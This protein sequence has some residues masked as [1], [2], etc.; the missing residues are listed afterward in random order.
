MPAGADSFSN[1]LRMGV[2]VFHALKEILKSKKLST[3]VGD[4]GGFAPALASNTA[5]LDLLMEAIETA[6]YRPGDDVALALDIAASEFAEDERPLSP[7]PR[8]RGAS[9]P[10]RWSAATRRSSNAIPSSR[11]RTASARTT[12]RAGRC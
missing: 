11:S 3:G 7:A 2:E 9:T 4:E 12:G 8:E 6:G 5:A 10:T 1:A